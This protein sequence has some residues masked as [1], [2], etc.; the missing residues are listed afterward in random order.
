MLSEKSKLKFRKI[1]AFF[2][3]QIITWCSWYFFAAI[4]RRFSYYTEAPKYYTTKGKKKV[5][6]RSSFTERLLSWMQRLNTSFAATKRNLK[7][8]FP[9]STQI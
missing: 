3:H 4:K 5:K 6:C 8:P 1:L 7:K 2:F 9:L